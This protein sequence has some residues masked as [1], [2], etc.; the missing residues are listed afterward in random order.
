MHRLARLKGQEGSNYIDMALIMRKLQ[1]GMALRIL[2]AFL[3]K[4][5]LLSLMFLLSLTLILL[6]AIPRIRFVPLVV[7]AISG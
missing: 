5:V 6:N 2:G 1:R 7:G 4:S 3:S